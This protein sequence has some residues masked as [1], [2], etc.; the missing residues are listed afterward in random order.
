MKSVGDK[1]PLIFKKI[2]LVTRDNITY[3]SPR[4]NAFWMSISTFIAIVAP[5]DLDRSLHKPEQL[6]MMPY[7]NK[8]HRCIC[9]GM[10]VAKASSLFRCL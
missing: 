3:V 7:S 10:S 2:R 5:C 1:V 9:V 6:E 4:E 8:P